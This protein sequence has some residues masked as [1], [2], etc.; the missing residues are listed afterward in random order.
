MSKHLEVLGYLRPNGGYVAIGDKYEGIDFVDC[1][2]ITKSEYDEIFANYDKIKAEQEKQLLE[3]KKIA[4]TKLAALGLTI[5][6]LKV[7]GLA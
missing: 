7:L 5:D 6:D 2:P 3:A 4:E 1:E